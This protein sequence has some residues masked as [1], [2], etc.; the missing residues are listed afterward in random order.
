MNRR[1]V[2]TKFQVKW[3]QDGFSRA[4]SMRIENAGHRD[5]SRKLYSMKV[6]CFGPLRN[7]S[8]QEGA[9]IRGI[10]GGGGRQGRIVAMDRVNERALNV[11]RDTLHSCIYR[12][13]DMTQLLNFNRMRQHLLKL[14]LHQNCSFCIRTLSRMHRRNERSGCEGNQPRS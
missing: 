10:K 2:K 5:L 13:E 9:A 12:L 3:I 7:M 1:T 11:R 4:Q 8:K 14:P 6:F